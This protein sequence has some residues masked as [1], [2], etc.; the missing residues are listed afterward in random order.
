MSCT[1][2]NYLRH[3]TLGISLFDV[4][5]HCCI[6]A[7]G[8]TI[9]VPADPSRISMSEKACISITRM[10]NASGRV[11]GSVY[12]HDA[13]GGY[14][15]TGAVGVCIW[16]Q[17]DELFRGDSPFPDVRAGIT[18]RRAERR[19]QRRVSRSCIF[20]IEQGDSSRVSGKR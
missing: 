8:R 9:C 2:A 11:D 16:P 13:D 3:V 10:V 18:P 12:T 6:V 14:E 17:H 19:R 1:F 20:V 15:L 7:V 5:S 4:I